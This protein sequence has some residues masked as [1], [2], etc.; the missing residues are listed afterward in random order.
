MQR[1]TIKNLKAA[2]LMLNNMTGNP[3]EAYKKGEDGK[4]TACIGNFHISQAYGGYSLHQM[5]NDGGGVR[6]IFNMGH[7]PARQLFDLI[8]AFR[9]GYDFNQFKG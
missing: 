6:D 3:V 1:I 8:H 2:A 9:R 5:A 7:M 4:Y